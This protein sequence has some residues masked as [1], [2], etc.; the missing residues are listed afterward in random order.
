[1]EAPLDDALGALRAIGESTRLRIVAALQHGALSV[2]ELTDLLGQSQPRISRHLRV[3]SDANV[4]ERRRE[5][6]R[7]FLSLNTS[8]PVAPIVAATL[9]AIDPDDPQ[10]AAVE[11]GL[12]EIRNARARVAEDYFSGVAE[13]WDE[14]RSRHAP[15]TEVEAAI[16]A[17]TAD[18]DYSSII[19]L[20]TGTGR[21][22]Q[23][24]AADRDLDR[25]VGI[26]TSPAMLAVARSRLDA[27]SSHVGS[28]PGSIELRQG[29]LLTAPVETGSFDLVVIHQVLHYLDDPDR[30]V[31]QAARLLAPGGHLLIVDLAPHDL[32][33]LVADHAHRR[34]GF[35]PD[36][37]AGW[38]DDA[39]LEDI[40]TTLI[41]PTDPHD[42]LTVVIW[43]ASRRTAA[44]ESVADTTPSGVST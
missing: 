21:M 6:T 20:G 43:R 34:L 28:G 12:A 4:I 23:L 3:L 36:K 19:D 31:Q 10:L 16:L 37:V 42:G 24:L 26:D 40:A 39:G 1:M 44:I 17:A 9:A 35:V 33:F 18:L 32:E 14:V 11:V 25:I 13:D 41:E 7:V 15:D 30:A 29:D 38:L 27:A 22:L 8:N 2:T 5:G